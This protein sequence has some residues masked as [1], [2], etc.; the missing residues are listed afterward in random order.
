M[1]KALNLSTESTK[2]TQ[3]SE[4]VMMHQPLLSTPKRPQAILE[5]ISFKQKSLLKRTSVR[6]GKPRV[7]KFR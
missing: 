1:I 3:G 2:A 4:K 5:Y 7:K 6:G